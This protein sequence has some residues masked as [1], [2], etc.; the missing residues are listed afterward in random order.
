MIRIRAT[1]QLFASIVGGAKE[2]GD[3]AADYRY[4]EIRHLHALGFTSADIRAL[5][6]TLNLNRG[7]SYPATHPDHEPTLEQ[8]ER[9][10][11]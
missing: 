7:R 4:H 10:I 2:E 9:L 3:S 1:Q 5:M 8:A 6:Q 11:D